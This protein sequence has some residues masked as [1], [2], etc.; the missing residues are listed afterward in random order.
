MEGRKSGFAQGAALD[1]SCCGVSQPEEGAG[2]KCQPWPRCWD[3]E[4][5]EQRDEQPW[6]V[7]HGSISL[8]AGP[9]GGEQRLSKGESEPG[10]SKAAT[11]E[12]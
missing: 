2:M 7:F 10:C 5:E 6:V 9:E 11:A 8:P 1:A 3:A 12:L 4:R